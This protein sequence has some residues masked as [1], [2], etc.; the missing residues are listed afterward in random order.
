[1]PKAAARSDRLVQL[2]AID[3][4]MRGRYR[5]VK[6]VVFDFRFDTS[7]RSLGGMAADM[8][9]VASGHSVDTLDTLSFKLRSRSITADRPTSTDTG[10]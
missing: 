7:A 2:L 6:F 4:S 5:T 10:A 1:L 3:K 8:R 9:A